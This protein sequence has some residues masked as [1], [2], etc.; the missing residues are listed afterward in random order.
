MIWTNGFIKFKTV[1]QQSFDSKGNPIVSATDSWSDFIACGYE[2]TTNLLATSTEKS[3]YISQ[4]F[5]IRIKLQDI[6]ERVRLYDKNQILL[7]EF[8]V[9]SYNH[10][11]YIDETHL[12]CLR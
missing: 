1:S 3:D 4:T 2:D 8:V 11:Q 7:G 5:S 6:K 10:Y 9:K 12:T